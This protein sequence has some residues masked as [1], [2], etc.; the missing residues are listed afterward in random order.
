MLKELIGRDLPRY[1]KY[2]YLRGYTPEQI[3]EAYHRTLEEDQEEDVYEINFTEDD[4]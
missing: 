2:M 1:D 3:Y 4:R